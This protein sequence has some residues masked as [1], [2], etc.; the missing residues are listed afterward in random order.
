L[1]A[2]NVMQHKG[3]FRRC[4]FTKNGIGREG[5]DGSAQH[6]QSVSYDCLVLVVHCFTEHKTKP[7]GMQTTPLSMQAST[8]GARLKPG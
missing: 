5:G 1:I 4:R 3:S 7:L 6:G 2:N 8:F